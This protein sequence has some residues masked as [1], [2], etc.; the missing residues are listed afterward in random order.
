MPHDAPPQFSHLSFSLLKR[1]SKLYPKSYP[2]LYKAPAL[3]LVS[4]LPI[5]NKHPPIYNPLTPE[6]CPAEN[7]V[8]AHRMP[9]LLIRLLSQPYSV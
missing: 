2:K 5:A 1:K 7:R 9:P 8:E 3:V 4:F 6:C